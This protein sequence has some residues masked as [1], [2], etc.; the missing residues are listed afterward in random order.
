MLD[1]N[2]KLDF[3]TGFVWLD[4]LKN[5]PKT[6]KHLKLVTALPCY[7]SK[8]QDTF[9]YMGENGEDIAS[10]PQY[11]Y[12]KFPKHHVQLRGFLNP[13]NA[14]NYALISYTNWVD[15]EQERVR[16]LQLK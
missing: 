1:E 2:L 13:K 6:G 16:F 14:Y 9:F 3:E 7:I 8:G 4:Y 10:K 15:K 12:V 11:W 5:Y